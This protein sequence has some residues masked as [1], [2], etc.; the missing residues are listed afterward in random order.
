MNTPWFGDFSWYQSN[1][2]KDHFKLFKDNGMRGAILRASVSLSKD[3]FFDQLADWC[4]ELDIK[5]AAYHYFYPGMSLDG[6]LSVFLSAI[7]QHLEV[8]SAWL[9]IEEYKNY[10]SGSFYSPAFLNT[11]YKTMRDKIKLALPAGIKYGNYSAQYIVN[12]YLS[13]KN[14]FGIVQPSPAITWMNEDLFWVAHYA[15]YYSWWTNYLAS[16]GASWDTTAKP[17]SISN[18]QNIMN[19]LAAHQVTGQFPLMPKGMTAFHAHQA[20]TFIP[21]KEFIGLYGGSNIDYNITTEPFLDL[22]FGPTTPPEVPEPEPI[23]IETPANLRYK[24][25]GSVWVRS[26]PDSSSPLN[27]IGW[28]LGGDVVTVLEIINGW[29][30]L[31][32]GGWIYA[33]Y[34]V[35]IV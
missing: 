28:R 4:G 16:L 34:L 3:K 26:T 15:K 31:L 18:L 35:L 2:T 9:D 33:K 12:G 23:I 25:T 1:H 13:T 22:I 29:A 7:D 17:I 8:K 20:I 21:L 24:V 27:I 11:S 19:T 10:N 32:E 14:I 30:R 5:I 6:Q